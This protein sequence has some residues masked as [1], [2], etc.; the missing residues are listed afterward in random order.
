MEY[1]SNEAYALRHAPSDVETAP[2][3]EVR[4]TRRACAPA[5]PS[6]SSRMMAGSKCVERGCGERGGVY[7]S[8]VEPV[9]LDT[10]A[11]AA[12]CVPRGRLDRGRVVADLSSQRSIG[13]E[14]S[15]R[16]ADSGWMHTRAV[17]VSH[18]YETDC[19][20]RTRTRTCP[21]SPPEPNQ[22]RG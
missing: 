4:T 2:A 11:R 7:V 6:R 13:S 22:R 14:A 21:P 1:T 5:G 19:H 17:D 18:G 3:A 10:I 9:R 12:G 8:R 16:S 20:P 15:L